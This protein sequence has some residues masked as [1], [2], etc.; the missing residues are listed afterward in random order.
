MLKKFR[1]KNEKGQS[2]VETALVLPIIILMLTG[3]IDFSLLLNN[4]LIICNA[5]REGARN[6][7]VG[8]SDAMI[9]SSIRNAS[10]TLDQ[11]KVSIAIHPAEA[12]RKRGD[13]ITVT[14]EYDYKLITPIIGVAVP[15]PFHLKAKAV[16]RME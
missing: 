5:S 16:M 10:S 14:V 8:F 6:A 11:N 9:V 12:L 4:Y 2:L 7:A 1:T 3:I 15:D 13:H